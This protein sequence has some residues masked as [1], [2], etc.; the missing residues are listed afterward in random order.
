MHLNLQQVESLMDR[1]V[2][3]FGK[4][5]T[6]RAVAEFLSTRGVSSVFYDEQP[7]LSGDETSDFLGAP[8]G[9][10]RLVIV[11]PGFSTQHAWV[12]AAR[13]MD[14]T[15]ITDLDLAA[16]YWTGK[17]LAITGTNGK[18]TLT[19]LLEQAL[20][21][22]GQ[23]A[24][25]CGNIGRPL[26][27]ATPLDQ[28]EAWAVCE[29]SSFQSEAM[30]NFRAD[31]AIWTNF[32]EDHLDR[33]GSLEAYFRAKLRL[34]EAC[35]KPGAPSW[36]GPTVAEAALELN[37]DLPDQTRIIP[38]NPGALEALD[39]RSPF[40]FTPQSEN[41][42]I[43]VAFW[44]HF[45]FA[46]EDL[47]QAANNFKGLPHRIEQVEDLKG[48]KIW[49]DSKAT[50]F[51]AAL[52]ALRRFD[53]RVQ[54]IAGGRSK[55]GDFEKFLKLAAPHVGKAYFIGEVA[56]ELLEH[57]RR[58]KIPAEPFTGLEAAIHAAMREARAP[59]DI[60]FSPGFASFDQ[61]LDYADRGDAFKRLVKK[62][63]V[64]TA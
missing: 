3:I 20:K 1:P 36:V 50:N 16:F 61:Y 47:L 33:H 41:F 58:Q 43:G 38:L 34:L 6:G 37:I 35:R 59:G 62:M 46:R 15:C 63:K 27:A 24:I 49:N 25:A 60:L 23:D 2:A 52:A 32:D 7:H 22:C 11:S 29:V 13:E 21:G 10:H 64:H 40:K 51:S 39:D 55:G 14:M 54:W 9:L 53:Q 28:P 8:I 45:G 19:L 42:S 12:K 4:G 57:A 44:E 30:V 18:S 56:L 5:V 17:T 26:V 48:L 31:A